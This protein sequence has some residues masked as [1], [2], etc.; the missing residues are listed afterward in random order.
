[1]ECHSSIRIS[2]ICSRFLSFRP[3]PALRGAWPRTRGVLFS[4]S[5][6]VLPEDSRGA[7]IDARVHSARALPCPGRGTKR[8]LLS[9]RRSAPGQVERGNAGGTAHLESVATVP[10]SRK[11][12]P[13]SRTQPAVATAP[14]KRTGRTGFNRWP[15]SIPEI[16]MTARS[17][18]SRKPGVSHPFRLM[19]LVWHWGRGSE[20]V[21]RGG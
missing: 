13:G 8:S 18:N 1:M 7:G 14:L 17:S 5:S 20:R 6:R 3:E 12:G 4:S 16:P 10:Q 21:S 2:P 9:G 15:T 19:C 11:R